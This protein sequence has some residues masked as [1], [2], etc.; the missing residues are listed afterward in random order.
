MTR[1]AKLYLLPLLF[2]ALTILSLALGMWSTAG[3]GM[4]ILA[5]WLVSLRDE[6]RNA[7]QDRLGG[8]R[9][10]SRRSGR[11]AWRDPS[12]VALGLVAGG[13]VILVSALGTGF[14]V[15]TVVAAGIWIALLGWWISLV[16]R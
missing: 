6:Y 13:A 9:T 14:T 12:N 5:A 4:V 2:A 15:G 11:S 7:A 3:I 10:P 16:Q 8:S 1:V